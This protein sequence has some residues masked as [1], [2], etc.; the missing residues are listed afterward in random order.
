MGGKGGE[1][2]STGTKKQWLKGIW[3]LLLSLSLWI[4]LYK[5][6]YIDSLLKVILIC[7]SIVIIVI[8]RLGLSLGDRL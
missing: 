2:L 8:Q 6:F 4:E 3:N 7:I 1:Y 5:L